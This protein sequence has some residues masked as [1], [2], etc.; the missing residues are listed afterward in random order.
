MLAA[1]SYRVGQT[2][3]FC[4]LSPEMTDDKNRSPVLLHKGAG[5]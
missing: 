5:H 4:G 1:G 3:V 2:I